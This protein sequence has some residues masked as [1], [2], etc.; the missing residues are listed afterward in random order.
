M[1]M[2]VQQAI[3]TVLTVAVT[4]VIGFFLRRLLVRRLRR[5]VLDAWLVE[6]LGVIVV[7]L[8]LLL[9]GTVTIG[10]WNLNNL[11]L[12][13]NGFRGNLAIEK[14]SSY[15]GEIWTVLLSAFIL[16]LGIGVGRTISKIT[17]RNLAE[18]RIDI[19]TRT[20]IGRMFSFVVLGIAIFWILAL[21]HLSIETPLAILGTLTVAFTFAIQDI[22]RDLVAGFYILI[23][24]PFHIGDEISI[25][26]GA[27]GMLTGRVEEVQLRATKVRLVSGE[28]VTIP[29]TRI[30]STTVINNTFYGERRVTLTMNLPRE[31]YDRDATPRQILGIL[32][33][34]DEIIPKPEPVATISGYTAQAV[35]LTVH[36]W[37]VHGQSGVISE[38]LHALCHAFADAE[39]TVKESAGAI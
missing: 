20:L 13:W 27:G 1:S 2:Q 3:Y 12:F 39:L 30:F 5:T 28:E 8:L 17:I 38:A 15:L 24:R 29:N 34:I 31:Q 36:F 32:R 37:I 19:N 35:T 9:G 6:T 4:A 10:I 22:L 26:G 16:V 21:W 11:L 25:D 23:E 18:N 33:E 14:L 7:L